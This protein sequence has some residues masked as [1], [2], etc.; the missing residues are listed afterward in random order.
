MA[1][2][3]T[4]SKNTVYTILIV[5]GIS[6]DIKKI[7]KSIYHQKHFAFLLMSVLGES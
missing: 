6:L 7:S 1:S 3:A 2:L 4:N 5:V